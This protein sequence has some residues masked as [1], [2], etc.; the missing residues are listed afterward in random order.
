V[1]TQNLSKSN[2]TIVMLILTILL[3]IYFYITGPLYGHVHTISLTFII[4]GFIGTFSAYK[5]KNLVVFI[6]CIETMLLGIVTA[7]IIT[8]LAV[9]DSMG[10]V[11]A[12]SILALAACE[13]AIGLGLIVNSY[14]TH[15]TL[16]FTRFRNLHSFRASVY[17]MG[18]DSIIPSRINRAHKQQRHK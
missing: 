17:Q 10:Q 9:D 11:Y 6:M 16:E 5:H 13:T 4:V 3:P 8:S 1:I 12:L 7:F 15:K 14:K 18:N 2:I